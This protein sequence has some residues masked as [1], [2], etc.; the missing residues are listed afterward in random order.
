MLA[1]LQRWKELLQ[2]FG[3]R[4]RCLHGRELPVTSLRADVPERKRLRGQ[5][6]LRVRG[7]QQ[8]QVL[9]TQLCTDM[10]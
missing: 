3:L 7:L 9:A 5:F 1:Q 4:I 8:R 10:Q 6:G 2:E